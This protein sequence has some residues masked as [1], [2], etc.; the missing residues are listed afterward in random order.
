MT[1][2]ADEVIKSLCDCKDNSVGK[3][4]YN[5]F[6]SN[7]HITDN[8]L[9]DTILQSSHYLDVVLILYFANLNSAAKTTQDAIVY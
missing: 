7:K 4:L 3:N 2:S 9:L 8:F 1:Y 5:A 6:I